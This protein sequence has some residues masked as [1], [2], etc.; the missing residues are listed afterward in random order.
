M[1]TSRNKLINGDF[2]LG[3]MTNFTVSN[4]QAV[5]GGPDGSTYCAEVA[6]TGNAYQT[7]T[8]GIQLDLVTVAFDFLPEYDFDADDTS[9]KVFVEL[10]AQY[11]EDSDE[12]TIPARYNDESG[13]I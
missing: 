8:P 2:E 4:V 1:A 7:V 9:T 13:V 10:S 11:T 6:T 12:F 3:A 5:A